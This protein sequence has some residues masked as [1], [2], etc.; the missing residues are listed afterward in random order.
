MVA[1]TEDISFS[2]TKDPG[3]IYLGIKKFKRMHTRSFLGVPGH[4]K[5]R[6]IRGKAL[7]ELKDEAWA[8]WKRQ[9][10]NV[11]TNGDPDEKD[12]RTMSDGV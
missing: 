12:L 10:P 5:R 11:N 9:H 4:P 2:G 6:S 3:T 1:V 7:R 8:E